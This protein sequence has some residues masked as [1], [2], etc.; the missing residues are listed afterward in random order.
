MSPLFLSLFN[1]NDPI[2]EPAAD[3][4]G[5]NFIAYDCSV[6]KIAVFERK[7]QNE[8]SG[9]GELFFELVVD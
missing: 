6:P 3:F 9:L 5:I 4:G 7:V 1:L 8:A 2:E